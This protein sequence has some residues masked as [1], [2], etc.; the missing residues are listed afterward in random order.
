MTG[1]P[2]SLIAGHE[3]SVH[4]SLDLIPLRGGHH[5]RS[6][7]LPWTPPTISLQPWAV[8]TLHLA[9]CTQVSPC[10]SS[11]LIAFVFA[12]WDLGTQNAAEEGVCWGLCD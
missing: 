10:T 5:Q 11:S 12:F 1:F 8:S 7:D 6:G 2:P 4:G 9:P 3:H